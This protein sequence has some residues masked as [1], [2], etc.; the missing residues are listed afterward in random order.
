[1]FATSEELCNPHHT[2]I[3]TCLYVC[4]N[5]CMCMYAHTYNSNCSTRSRTRRCIVP[6]QTSMA[7]RAVKCTQVRTRAFIHT[8][9]PYH[10]SSSQCIYV[11]AESSGCRGL[12]HRPAGLCVWKHNHDCRRSDQAPG[13]H[14]RH[15]WMYCALTYG[16]TV[17]LTYCI[18]M[19]VSDHPDTRSTLV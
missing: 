18:L 5:V 2:Y 17:H 13:L 15:A 4:L 9:P 3:H 6:K 7:N 19:A 16:I 8:T 1:M 10:H 11:I 12:S 14:G